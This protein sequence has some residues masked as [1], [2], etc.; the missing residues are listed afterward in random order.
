MVKQREKNYSPLKYAI[1]GLFKAVTFSTDPAQ[2]L[3][4]EASLI[5]ASRAH[6]VQIMEDDI[7]RT[8]LLAPIF[9]AILKNI[10]ND[11]ISDRKMLIELDRKI[12]S[13]LPDESSKVRGFEIYRDIQYC[14]E[15]IRRWRVANN[16]YIQNKNAWAVS[17]DIIT[18]VN[19]QLIEI[20][21][22]HNLM[23]FPKGEFYNVDDTASAIGR[24]MALGSEEDDDYQKRR[25]NR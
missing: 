21:A 6:L 19:T 5:N 14:D 2:T 12:D 15:H 17:N 8:D 13:L 10:A 11:T 18:T 25:G 1:G 7:P 23:A 3:G 9:N 24:V 16:T 4:F 20:I 22:R